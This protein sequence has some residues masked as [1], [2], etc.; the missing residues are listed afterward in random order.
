MPILGFTKSGQLIAQNIQ[1]GRI[2]NVT[3]PTL[4]VAVWTHIVYVYSTVRRLLLYVNGTYISTTE[5]FSYNTPNSP[6]NLYIGNCPLS[7]QCHC[8]LGS[9]DPKQYHGAIDEFQVYSR[10]LSVNDIQNLSNLS[11]T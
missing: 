5:V 2:I 11:N 10:E 4:P 9:I 1:A 6:V 3:G 7:N 8:S